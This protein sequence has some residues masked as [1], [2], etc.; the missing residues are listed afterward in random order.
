MGRRGREVVARLECLAAHVA[1]GSAAAVE[2]PATQPPVP[3]PPASSSSKSSYIPSVPYTEELAGCHDVE[4]SAT[5]IEFFKRNGFLVKRGLLDGAALGAVRDHVFAQAPSFVRRDDRSTWVNPPFVGGLHNPL[6]P[7]THG[8][9]GR[10]GDWGVQ[11]EPPPAGSGFGIMSEGR[12]EGKPGSSWKLM[13][14]TPNPATGEAFGG[15]IFGQPARGLGAEPWLLEL[16]ANAPAMRSVVAQLCGGPIR[17]CQRTR[18]VYTI[19]PTT[20]HASRTVGGHNDGRPGQL[21][22]MV[23][24]SDVPPHCGGFHVWP[25]SPQR[26]WPYWETSQGNEKSVEGEA[27]YKAELDAIRQTVAP[28]EIVGKAGD[29]CFWHHRSESR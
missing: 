24:A 23:L 2:P 12:G 25:G 11:P 14:P 28:A 29:V 16:T 15:D 9:D 22:A 27:A 7:V 20:D 6:A 19:W 26:L 8:K 21:S 13:S 3:A 1:S 4:V 5:E 10:R 18:G 17:L